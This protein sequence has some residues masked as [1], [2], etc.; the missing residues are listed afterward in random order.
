MNN[1]LEYY[2]NKGQEDA[3]DE[4]YNPPHGLVDEISTWSGSGIEKM[5]EETEAYD[6]GYYGTKAQIDK[7]SGS[8]YNPPP[9]EY[10]AAREAYDNAWEET[11]DSSEEE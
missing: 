9:S 11:E 4:N 10:F 3:S 2:H 1:D 6:R 8:G 7:S 5:V